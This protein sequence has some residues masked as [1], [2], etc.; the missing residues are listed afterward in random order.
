M[1]VAT[2][3]SSRCLYGQYAFYGLMSHVLVKQ[4]LSVRVKICEV[5]SYVTRIC[6]SSL[7]CHFKNNSVT[8]DVDGFC[9]TALADEL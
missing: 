1:N 7:F 4:L 2:P 5:C 8:G 6:L 3:K 9:E